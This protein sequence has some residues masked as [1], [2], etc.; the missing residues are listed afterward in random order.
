MAD[1]LSNDRIEHIPGSFAEYTFTG[2][3]VTSVIGARYDYHLLFG[4]QFVPR[5]HLKYK[6]SERTDL[7]L[8]SGKGWR[9]PNY[10]IDNV[11]LLANSFAWIPADDT[12]LKFLGMLVA[13]STK[14]L[15]YLKKQRVLRLIFIE[16]GLKIN[17][18]LTVKMML[19]VLSISKR[20]LFQTVFRQNCL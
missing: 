19:F 17:L 2:S 15:S 12:L 10:M 5:A 11:S 3:R 14:S 4:G 16:H 9:V 1:S 18:L 6:L 7:R 13:Q 8:T 20:S